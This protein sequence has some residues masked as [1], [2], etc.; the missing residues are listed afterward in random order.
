M[1]HH[2]I[3][4]RRRIFPTLVNLKLF[5]SYDRLLSFFPSSQH[6]LCERCETVRTIAGWRHY[7]AHSRILQLAM[8]GDQRWCILHRKM[9]SDMQKD[10][11][12]VQI[13]SCDASSLFLQ[14]PTTRTFAEN[15]SFGWLTIGGIPIFY[16]N[17]L[18]LM[19]WKFWTFFAKY[20]WT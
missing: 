10:S 1:S 8:Q 19:R 20:F 18:D 7:A 11:G 4:F 17:V 9:S 6:Y 14:S 5:Q 13:V 15:C 12:D 16:M 2:H 3:V